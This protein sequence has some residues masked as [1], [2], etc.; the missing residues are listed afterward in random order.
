[1]LFN[2]EA[3]YRDITR[4]PDGWTSRPPLV[5]VAD[6]P[7]ILAFSHVNFMLEKY[8]HHL[9]VTL[10]GVDSKLQLDR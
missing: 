8:Y 1:M 5:A 3:V 6:K 10:L 7:H 2:P 4:L 9:L